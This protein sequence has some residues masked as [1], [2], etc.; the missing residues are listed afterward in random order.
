M[1]SG[2]IL[3]INWGKWCLQNGIEVFG[4][5]KLESEIHACDNTA[6]PFF[7]VKQ[8]LFFSNLKMQ[9]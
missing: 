1:V 9:S 5:A 6:M 7:A 4:R 2:V 3:V 8:A